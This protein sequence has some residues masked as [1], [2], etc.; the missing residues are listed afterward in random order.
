MNN[1]LSKT[2]RTIRIILAMAAGFF[3]LNH[4][5]F[6]LTDILLLIAA[7]V[8]F[9]TGLKGLCPIYDMTGIKSLQSDHQ[10]A[11]SGK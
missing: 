6:R 7:P 1:N 3:L 11:V 10:H 2:D 8:L 4:P 5:V 9:Q